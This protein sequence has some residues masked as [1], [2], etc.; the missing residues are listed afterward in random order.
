[1]AEKD[2]IIK[3]K[4]DHSGVFDFSAF[5]SFA[6]GWLKNELYGVVEEKYTEKVSGK[7]RDI[8]IEWKATKMISDYFKIEHSIKMDIKELVDVEVE[9]DGK[10]KKMNKGSISIE[11]KG[12]LIKDW[13]SKWD[14][15]PNF[16]FLR[17]VY[18]K[19]IIRQR[20]DAMEDKVSG[21]ARDFKEELKAFLELA[22]KR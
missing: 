15:T 6:H 12:S 16:R 13:E 22:G 4:L 9:I 8:Y 7:G 2:V 3:E 17:E 11:V 19:Y 1:M 18:N 20:V 10:K 5:Y 21:D 14:T